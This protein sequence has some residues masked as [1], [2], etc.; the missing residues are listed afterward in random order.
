MR[1]YK[2]WNS[3]HTRGGRKSSCDYGA[4]ESD[5]RYIY[6]GTSSRNSHLFASVETQCREIDGELVFTLHVDGVE[7]K[8][9]TVKKGEIE[10]TEAVRLDC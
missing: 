8:R 10:F 7:V 3:V 1:Q 4:N 2:I 9:A 6:V 5:C